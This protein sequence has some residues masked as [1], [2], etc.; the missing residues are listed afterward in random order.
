MLFKVELAGESVSC[1]SPRCIKG[2][3][4]RGWQLTDPAQSDDFLKALAAEERT[5]TSR[6]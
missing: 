4:Q 3:L 1:S 6:H 2:L 5:E